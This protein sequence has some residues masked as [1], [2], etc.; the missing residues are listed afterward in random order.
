MFA[1]V[2]SEREFLTVFDILETAPFQMQSQAA[3]VLCTAPDSLF[4]DFGN[5]YVV[6]QDRHVLVELDETT[7]PF[8]R[9]DRLVF[10]EHDS[11]SLLAAGSPFRQQQH[12]HVQTEV[13]KIPWIHPCK[14][15]TSRH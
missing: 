11:K 4:D 3:G 10:K 2:E 13:Q 7:H 8:A 14:S 5:P 9:T 6:Y 15:W 12:L 1:L